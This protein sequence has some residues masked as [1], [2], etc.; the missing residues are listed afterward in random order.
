MDVDRRPSLVLGMV[1]GPRVKFW[2]IHFS[3]HLGKTDGDVRLLQFVDGFI[4]GQGDSP[5]VYIVCGKVWI[6]NEA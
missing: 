2:E 5:L 3:R 1:E 4:N 6:L